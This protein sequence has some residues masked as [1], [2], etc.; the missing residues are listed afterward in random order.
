MPEW[1]ISETHYIFRGCILN[2]VTS[3]NLHKPKADN[4]KRGKNK[5]SAPRSHAKFGQ[6]CF[7]DEGMAIVMKTR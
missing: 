7:T 3:T 4:G 6:G 2:T 1:Q 5:N